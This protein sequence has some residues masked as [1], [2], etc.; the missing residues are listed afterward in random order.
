MSRTSKQWWTSSTLRVYSW[1]QTER[2]LPR[3]LRKPEC[4]PTRSRPWLVYTPA[5]STGLPLPSP[6]RSSPARMPPPLRR[7]GRLWS[8]GTAVDRGGY[9]MLHRTSL[10]STSGKRG[11][12]TASVP[13]PA[14]ATTRRGLLRGI[15]QYLLRAIRM[16]SSGW[17]DRL[18]RGKL[19]V[20]VK[21]FA[22]KNVPSNGLLNTAVPTGNLP[23]KGTRDNQT[24]N[25]S[26]RTET[27][28]TD[29]LSPGGNR[30]CLNVVMG[31]VTIQ[32]LRQR[33]HRSG[34]ASL[35]TAI[36]SLRL[37]LR[38]SHPGPERPSS[39]CWTKT[40]TSLFPR[41]RGGSSGSA[42]PRT[43]TSH[44]PRRVGNTLTQPAA[45][46]LQHPR[47]HIWTKLTLNRKGMHAARQTMTPW[48]RVVVT[49]ANILQTL[50]K[51]KRVVRRASSWRGA[52]PGARLC[53]QCYIKFAK[54]HSSRDP[55]LSDAPPLL[56]RGPAG[57]PSRTSPSY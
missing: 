24:A 49:R 39:T 45:V 1:A 14:P 29:L 52:P 15:G 6:R 30:T 33:L 22:N 2:A 26:I 41:C 46:H 11:V 10:P 38:L 9:Q 4:S 28:K 51:K 43:R 8:Q 17:N 36:H 40:H 37:P 16:P 57:R 20:R 3:G 50:M 23:G 32:K 7:S 5:P 55:F 12:T 53:M 18:Q 56:R 21:Q 34:G 44:V 19:P 54:G 25:I 35:P 42:S 31:A 48:A 47:R 27:F 13:T